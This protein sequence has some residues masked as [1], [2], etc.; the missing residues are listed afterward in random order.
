MKLLKLQKYNIYVENY[1]N[2]TTTKTNK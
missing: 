1:K 2:L